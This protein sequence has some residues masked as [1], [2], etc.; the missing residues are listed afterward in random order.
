[1]DDR[2]RGE[3]AMLGR[4][5]TG[6]ALG[7]GAVDAEFW[8]LVCEDK[9]WLAAEFD[10]LVSDA[11]E[12]PTRFIRRLTLTDEAPG[13]SVGSRWRV[14]EPSRPWRSSSG[15]VPHWRRERGPPRVAKTS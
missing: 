3:I 5:N 4:E 14:C 9:E 7:S 15:S 1:M 2:Q 8:A 12:T 10:E 6:S 11:W 13:G